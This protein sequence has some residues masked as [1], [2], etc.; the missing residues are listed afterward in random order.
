MCNSTKKAFENFTSKT[1]PIFTKNFSSV[2]KNR[3]LPIFIPFIGIFFLFFPFLLFSTFLRKLT[4]KLHSLG[5]SLFPAK[6][7]YTI[8]IA[9]SLRHRLHIQ[10]QSVPKSAVFLPPQKKKKVFRIGNISISF[11]KKHGKQCQKA[12]SIALDAFFFLFQRNQS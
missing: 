6:K 8:L 3:F 2:I 12:S 1:C 4:H 9:D 10:K 11:S 7:A 5:P